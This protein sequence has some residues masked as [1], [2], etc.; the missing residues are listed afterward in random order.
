MNVPRR[1]CIELHPN[2][3]SAGLARVFLTV[4]QPTPFENPSPSFDVS[5]RLGTARR[6]SPSA[7]RG[8]SSTKNQ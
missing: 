8:Q 3:V 7:V 1:P 4:C 5:S 2:T 6:V